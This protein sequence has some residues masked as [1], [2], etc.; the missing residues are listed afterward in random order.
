M[1]ASLINRIINAVLNSTSSLLGVKPLIG[2]P[3][4]KKDFGCEDLNCLIPIS[5]S[6]IIAGYICISLDRRSIEKVKKLLK[7]ESEIVAIKKLAGLVIED[8]KDIIDL[9]NKY[10]KEEGPL[11]VTKGQGLP[12]EKFEGHTISMPMHNNDF[13]LKLEINLY[14]IN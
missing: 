5:V 12:I 8:I 3:C 13:E 2:K 10:N 9:N 11:I 4:V 1:D 6:S 7:Q 14:S